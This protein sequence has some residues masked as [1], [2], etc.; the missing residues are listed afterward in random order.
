MTLLSDIL[1]T[2]EPGYHAAQA[3]VIDDEG[4]RVPDPFTTPTG[5]IK[6]AT[7]NY[8]TTPTGV[9][10]C[11]NKA[12]PGLCRKAATAKWAKVARCVVCLSRPRSCGDRCSRRCCR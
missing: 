8:R 11:G 4:Q 1:S 3:P 2:I 12:T 5:K 9:C 10:S 7:A 6:R